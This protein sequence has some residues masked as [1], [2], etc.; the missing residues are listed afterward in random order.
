MKT[1]ALILMTVIM[2]LTGNAQSTTN[3]NK[4]IVFIHGAWSTGEVW[5]NYKTYFSEKGHTILTP[6]FNYHSANQN[7]ALIGVSMEDYVNQIRTIV[8]PL[9]TPPTIVAHSM[10]CIIAQRL[11]MEG[12]IEKM[13]LI[14]PPANY[15]MMPPSE[16]IN[17]VKWVNKVAQL[18]ES[19]A[20]PTFEQAVD[21]MLHNLPLPKQQEVYSKMTFESG[22]VM[23]EMIWIKN[24]FG[25]KPNKIKYSKI[26]IPILFVSGGVDNASPVKI[27]EKLMKKYKP[28]AELKVFEK[29]AHW[30]MEEN[31]WAAIAEYMT[32]WMK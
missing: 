31:N 10:G 19:L 21:G 7:D 12:L 23:K 3:H 9:D 13:I 24:L 29:N 18:K 28:N 1:I 2:N 25:K 30:M 11:A 27:S 15:G 17:S 8:E 22:L 20:K 32:D 14:A 5:D 26:D 6:T 16:S 4:T